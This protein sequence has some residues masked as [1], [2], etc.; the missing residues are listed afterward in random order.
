[1]RFEVYMVM[2][3]EFMVFWV[4]TLCAGLIPVF[5]GSSVLLQNI[6]V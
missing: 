6:D 3:M 4:V 1:V 5:L 2:K